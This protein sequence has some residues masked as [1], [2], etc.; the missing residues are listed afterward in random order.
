MTERLPI[1]RDGFIW[2]SI[3]WITH[4]AKL[5]ICLL[6]LPLAIQLEI[7]FRRQAALVDRLNVPF[8]CYATAV[9]TATKE[10]DTAG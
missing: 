6:I 2:K 7:N 4:V 3:S 9:A 5:F 1:P 10:E 8:E